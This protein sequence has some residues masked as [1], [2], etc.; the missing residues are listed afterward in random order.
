M[1]TFFSLFGSH[2]SKSRS[3]SRHPQTV[4]PAIENLENRL[5]PTASVN[6]LQAVA[7]NNGSAVFFQNAHTGTLCEKTTS[8]TTISLDSNVAAFSAG[9]DSSGNADVFTMAPNNSML[10]FNSKGVRAINPPVPMREFAAVHGD[11]LFAVGTNGSLWEFSPFFSNG[12]WAL[13]LPNGEANYVDAVTQSSGVD[14]LFAVLSNGQLE[15]S[16]NNGVFHTLPGADFTPGPNFFQVATISAGLDVNGNADVFALANATG[17]GDL[18]RWT[19]DSQG[20]TELGA[21]NQ[22]VRICATN[23]GQVFCLTSG[24]Q[25]DKFDAQNNF[26]SLYSSGVSE[27]AAASSH[28]VYFSRFDGSLW[29]RSDIFIFGSITVQWEASN[30]VL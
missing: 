30:T 22:F 13:I 6:I 26:H 19:N 25:L 28:D 23:N 29:E 10:E 27:V 17:H 20:W 2:R 12:G 1:K 5:V 16:F 3:N 18:F 15:E 11:R 7:V 9:V 21:E 8:G 4:R 24:G 14:A